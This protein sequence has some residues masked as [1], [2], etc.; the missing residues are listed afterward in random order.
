MAGTTDG[1]WADGSLL[2]DHARFLYFR[3]ERQSLS[4]VTSRRSGACECVCFQQRWRDATNRRRIQLRSDDSPGHSGQ[5]ICRGWRR[6]SHLR[7]RVRSGYGNNDSSRLVRHC[8]GAASHYS[9]LRPQCL[10]RHAYTLR[11]AIDLLHH[12]RGHSR[13]FRRCYRHNERRQRHRA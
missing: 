11:A 10:Q 6:G 12:S 7:L 2:R 9:R 8:G 1:E 4:D 13:I 3:R 5:F